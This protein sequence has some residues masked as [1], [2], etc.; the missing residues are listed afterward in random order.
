MEKVKSK[1]IDE[2][3]IKSM[4]QKSLTIRN[5]KVLY[6]IVKRC[7][8]ILGGL[9]GVL[10]LIP[11]A[12]VVWVMRKKNKEQ[13]PMYYT[14]LRI[15]KNGRIFKLYKFRSMVIGA[16]D[17]LKKY[18]KENPKE[19]KEYKKFKKLKYDPRITKTG[20]FL[21]KTSLDEWP[22]FINILK[23]D[24]SLIGPRPYLPREIEDM[25]IY[26]DFIIKAKPGLSGP[27]QVGGRSEITF[28]DRMQIDKEYI[29]NQ[30]IKND[31]II[32]LKTFLQVFKKEGAR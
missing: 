32:L 23:G 27:W 6:P 16:D 10:L 1:S 25:G 19:A 21:R 12:F 9:V 4:N 17:A 26:Y 14:Q 24:M 11:I 30:S 15:G 28:D 31:I 13:G 22:Q 7:I 20:S 2:I 5:K 8:D 29:Q 18:L 3:E